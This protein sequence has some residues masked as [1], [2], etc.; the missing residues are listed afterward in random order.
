[1]QSNV[2]NTIKINLSFLHVP[3]YPFF[4]YR[5]NFGK[6]NVYFKSVSGK[7][8]FKEGKLTTC[9]VCNH[10]WS[11]LGY[12]MDQRTTWADFICKLWSKLNTIFSVQRLT[13]YNLMFLSN[14][15][16]YWWTPRSRLRFQ[17]PLS[18]RSFI[19][20]FCSLDLLPLS[21]EKTPNDR[22][23]FSFTY[24]GIASDEQ[25]KFK[26]SIEESIPRG[27]NLDTLTTINNFKNI[28]MSNNLI[29]SP[30]QDLIRYCKAEAM[31]RGLLK[32]TQMKSF[33]VKR[34][35]NARKL[36]L[37]HRKLKIFDD[38]IIIKLEEL[39]PALLIIGYWCIFKFLFVI[40]VFHWN[41]KNWIWKNWNR[42]NTLD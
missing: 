30:H 16:S 13:K 37:N 22:S 28:I 36:F 35:Q 20:C 34:T 25:Q 5:K 1:M 18:C 29:I 2:W 27:I 11:G 21:K 12:I 40:G 38:K 3:F 8:C 4:S 33:T 6:L 39:R 31:E 17:Y 32:L 14:Y 19:F 24:F 23:C 26:L 41:T 15:S 42:L 7:H 10:L 9:Q